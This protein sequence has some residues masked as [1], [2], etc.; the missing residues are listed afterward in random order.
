MVLEDDDVRQSFL[1]V[2]LCFFG[3]CRTVRRRQRKTH[4]SRQQLLS[5]GW[6]RRTKCRSNVDE[7][8]A[9]VEIT[10]R[11]S[12]SRSRSR[13]DSQNV[14]SVHFPLAC[15]NFSGRIASSTAK[16][17]AGDPESRTYEPTKI[18]SALYLSALCACVAAALRCCHTP[19]A[20]VL[21]TRCNCTSPHGVPRHRPRARARAGCSVQSA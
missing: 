15:W 8:P 16:G 11:K 18:H 10:E 2:P 6:R 14:H 9:S 1:A 12:C 7:Y 21:R 4:L 3:T 19:P 17:A 20:S 13:C 5:S